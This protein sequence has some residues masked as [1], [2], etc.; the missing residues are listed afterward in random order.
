M[1]AMVMTAFGGPEVL[2]LKQVPVP[3]PGPLDLLLK[4][5]A[6]AVNPV[7][8]K[9]RNAPRWGDRA[10]PMIL[11]F[12]V[13]G[14]VVAM[15]EEVK[16]FAEG[17]QVYA[18]PSLIRDG[19]NSEYV[20]IDARSAAR[21]P[22][23]ISLEEAAALPLASLTAW[24]SLFDHGG[25]SPGDT[26]M[27]QGGAGGVGHI[28]IQLAKSKGCR[29]ITTAGR[30]ESIELCQRLGAD[31]VVDYTQQDVVGRVLEET[32]GAGCDVVF[33]TV[34]GEVFTQCIELVSLNGKLV[35]IVPGIPGDNLNRLFGRNASLHFE[36][37]GATLLQGRDP[38]HQG[39]ILEQLANLVDEN[40]LSPAI[41]HVW[42]LKELPEA[43]R[44][45]ETQRSLGKQLVRVAN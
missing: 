41:E 33:D 3:E 24:E 9:T 16:S 43:H 12:D 17:T 34:G 18:S 7:D 20:C 40:Q 19:A 14:T 37:M 32:N 2:Q 44:K 15:G 11:G 35:T 30:P 5:Q 1:R 10:P 31:V 29:V 13:A 22:K 38:T 23:K 27:I 4:V 39:L 45:Q 28:A 25:A 36:F 8:C 26:V 42:D 21:V 6:T